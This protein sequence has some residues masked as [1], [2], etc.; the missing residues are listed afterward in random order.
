MV[1]FQLGTE[2]PK[3]LFLH[4]QHLGHLVVGES[5]VRGGVG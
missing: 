2:T 4:L 3:V 5:K 1:N